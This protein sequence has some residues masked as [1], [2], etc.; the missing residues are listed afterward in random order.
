MSSDELQGSTALVAL[1]AV[2]SE[3]RHHLDKRAHELIADGAGDD[4]D[5]L[6]STELAEWFGVSIQWV[7]IA[8][9]KGPGPPWV[10]LSTRRIRYHRSAVLGWLTSRARRS[11]R[12]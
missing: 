1:N 9:H 10:A 11:T 3:P 12:G 6:T 2:T 8:R 5:L 7:E 4:D